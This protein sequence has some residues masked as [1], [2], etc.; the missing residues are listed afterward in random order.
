LKKLFLSE[1]RIFTPIRFP[2]PYRE[3]SKQLLREYADT[4]LGINAG[5]DTARFNEALSRSKRIQEELWLDAA[6]VAQNDRTAVTAV[7][8]NSLERNNRSP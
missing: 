3:H 4:R 8:V 2:Q 7:Y 1:P 5:L 6:T